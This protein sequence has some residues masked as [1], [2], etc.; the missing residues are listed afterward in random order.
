MAPFYI[1]SHLMVIKSRLHYFTNVS[2]L[3]VI[4]FIRASISLCNLLLAESSP[5]TLAIILL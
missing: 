4:L 5:H 3:A 1:W 2:I